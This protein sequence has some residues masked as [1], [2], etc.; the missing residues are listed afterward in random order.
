[1][2]RTTDGHALTG[3]LGTSRATGG[4]PSM[5]NTVPVPYSPKCDYGKPL[6]S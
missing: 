2:Q 6:N 4:L 5:V 3:G 1:M